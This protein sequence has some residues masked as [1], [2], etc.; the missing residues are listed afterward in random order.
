MKR[1]VKLV[2]LEKDDF[3]IG[4]ELVLRSILAFSKN[5]GSKTGR[6]L[7]VL[8]LN[9]PEKR[10]TPDCNLGGMKKTPFYGETGV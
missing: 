5:Q 6:D 10:E 3:E 8:Q 1:E 2:V 9:Q 7:I 4:D